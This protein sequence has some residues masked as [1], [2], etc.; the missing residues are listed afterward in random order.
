MA[1]ENKLK[2]GG[3]ENGRKAVLIIDSFRSPLT[4]E[5]LT[6]NHRKGAAQ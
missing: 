4:T 2:K 1:K 6:D 5:E 3:Y